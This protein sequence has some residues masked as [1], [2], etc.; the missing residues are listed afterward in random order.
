MPDEP[1]WSEVAVKVG[2]TETT[3]AEE[4]SLEQWVELTRCYDASSSI[5]AQSDEEVFDVVDE[6]NEVTGQATRAE[7]HEKGFEASCG[8]YFCGEWKE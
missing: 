2:C 1:A 4:L 3:R 6:K 8:S 5:P 7:V